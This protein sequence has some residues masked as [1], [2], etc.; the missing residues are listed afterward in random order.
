MQRSTLNPIYNEAIVFDVPQENV[1][2]VSLL[3]K[4]IDYDRLVLLWLIDTRE[5]DYFNLTIFSWLFC[6]WKM[7]Q[8]KPP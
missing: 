7:N 4:V 1:E 8:G 2:E 5:A 3:I 6:G